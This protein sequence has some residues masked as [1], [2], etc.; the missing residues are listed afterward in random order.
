MISV[1]VWAVIAAFGVVGIVAIALGVA[2]Q[3]LYTRELGRFI[4]HCFSEI[5]ERLERD[6]GPSIVV[7]ESVVPWWERLRL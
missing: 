6:S 3:V 2:Y 5:Q 4:D 7:K 1:F